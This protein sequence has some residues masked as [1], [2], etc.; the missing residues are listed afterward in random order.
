MHACVSFRT[1][2]STCIFRWC[3]RRRRHGLGVI[4]ADEMGLGKT[5]QGVAFCASLVDE[6]FGG[7]FLIVRA[8][9][10]AGVLLQCVRRGPLRWK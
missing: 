10:Y 7:P 9:V 2:W 6:V 8:R 1:L 4:L 5:V 3:W